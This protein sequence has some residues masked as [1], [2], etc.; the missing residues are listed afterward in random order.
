M[1]LHSSGLRQLQ[2]Q[3]VARIE[4]SE[5]R[6]RS[7]SLNAAPLNPGYD[8]HSPRYARLISGFASSSTGNPSMKMRPFRSGHLPPSLD[9]ARK[10]HSITSSAVIC[11]IKGTVRPSALAVFMLI[12]SSNL[13]GW[14]TGKSDGLAPLRTLPT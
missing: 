13:V 5:I 4:R 2:P 12:T 14:I 8:N 6:E 10:I 1:S 11:M 9:A 7:N 3:P